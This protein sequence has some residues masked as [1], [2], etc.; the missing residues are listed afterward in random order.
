MKHFEKTLFIVELDI[1]LYV[2]YHIET[3]IFEGSKGFLRL[4]DGPKPCAIRTIPGGWYC[5]KG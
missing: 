1:Q 4:F 5:K 3:F 2:S